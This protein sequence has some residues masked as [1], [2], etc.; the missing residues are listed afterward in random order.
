[1]TTQ[2]SATADRGEFTRA[3]SR[4]GASSR[5]TVTGCSAPSTMPKTWSRRPTCRPG[6]PMTASRAALP[7]VHEARSARDARARRRQHRQHLLDLRAP[8]RGRG[9]GLCRQQAC[10]RRHH[11]VSRARDRQVGNPRERSGARPDRHWHADALHRH[12]G[13]KGTSD[14]GGSGGPAWPSGGA[15]QRSSSSHPTRPHTSPDTSSRATAATP[16]AEPV[17][18]P[19]EAVSA[20]TSARRLRACHRRARDSPGGG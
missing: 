20:A 18:A 9:R 8:G 12:A 6:G 15:C 1:M 14:G 13:E 11:Q 17:P 4:T 5:L 3:R 10:R 7:C 19:G 16:P 2:A